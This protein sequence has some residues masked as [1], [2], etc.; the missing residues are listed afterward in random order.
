MRS[1]KKSKYSRQTAAPKCPELYEPTS[2][3]KKQ[4]KNTIEKYPLQL[5]YRTLELF[6]A[7]ILTRFPSEAETQ[8]QRVQ[9]S[10]PF[11]FLS[12]W[13]CSGR[14]SWTNF[15]VMAFKTC[16]MILHKADGDMQKP[17]DKDQRGQPTATVCHSWKQLKTRNKYF[18]TFLFKFQKVLKTI[19]PN[20]TAWITKSRLKLTKLPIYLRKLYNMNQYSINRKK[21]EKFSNTEILERKIRWTISWLHYRINDGEDNVNLFFKALP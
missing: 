17:N 19:V 7:T 13:P 15:S 18:L 11:F 14:N 20:K 16:G 4:L 9:I 8:F 3:S 2:M 5:K 12:I 6:G 10:S 21:M 1:S